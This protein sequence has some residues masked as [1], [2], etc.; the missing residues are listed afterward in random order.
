VKWLSTYK[1]TW[2]VCDPAKFRSVTWATLLRS[3]AVPTS[4]TMEGDVDDYIM[5]TS[6]VIASVVTQQRSPLAVPMLSSTCV[7]SVSSAPLLY[8]SSPSACPLAPL[9][10]SPS[11]LGI[12]SFLRSHAFVHCFGCNRRSTPA[13]LR[14]TSL[15]LTLTATTAATVQQQSGHL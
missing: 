7:L 8:C 5:V 11:F 6:G 2:L 1:T 3:P 15:L 13:V 9:S 10:S 12:A 4:C 14:S